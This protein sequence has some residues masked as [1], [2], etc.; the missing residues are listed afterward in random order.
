M[1]FNFRL[2]FLTIRVANCSENMNNS[3]PVLLFDGVCNLCNKL[4]MF[5]IR[6]DR[7]GKIRFAA[8]QSESGK[9]LLRTYGLSDKD[10]NFVVYIT[11]HTIFLKSSA[12]LHLLK[13]IGNGWNLFFGLIMI[14]RFIRDFFYDLVARSRYRIFGKRGVCMIPSPDIVNRFLL[15]NE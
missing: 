6:K 1:T 5:I 14:P 11:S 2:F 7:R 8:L 10:I 9:S 12:V 4:V 3:D 15:Q 13:D